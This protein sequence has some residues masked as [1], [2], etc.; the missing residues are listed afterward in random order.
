MDDTQE[1]IR[2]VQKNIYL[3]PE[4]PASLGID[5][6]LA[7]LLHLTA[8]LELSGDDVIEPED[9]VDVMDNIGLYLARLSPAQQQSVLAQVERVIEYAH[10]S[11]WDGDT[12][13]FLTQFLDEVGIRVAE[14]HKP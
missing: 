1:N 11:D 5:P 9:T 14:Q 2:W 6:M 13:D 4:L 8:F 7:A 10:R 3:L 12:T